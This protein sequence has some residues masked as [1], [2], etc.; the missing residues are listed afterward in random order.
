MGETLVRTGKSDAHLEPLVNLGAISHI[1]IVVED[2]E[3]AIKFYGEIFGV[4]PFEIVD[5]DGSNAEPKSESEK[6]VKNC[7]RETYGIKSVCLCDNARVV[8]ERA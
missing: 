6:T 3:Q 7:Q 1:G 5:F 4:G 8:R 2:L